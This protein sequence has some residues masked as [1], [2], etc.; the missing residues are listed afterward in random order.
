MKSWNKLCYLLTIWR[1]FLVR[2]ECTIN[3]VAKGAKV[4]MTVLGIYYKVYVH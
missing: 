4:K 2:D 1:E 3:D